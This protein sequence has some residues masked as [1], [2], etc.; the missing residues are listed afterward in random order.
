M[1]LR[2]DEG[3]GAGNYCFKCKQINND[4]MLYRGLDNPSF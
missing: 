1:N 3:C 4:Y 2:S